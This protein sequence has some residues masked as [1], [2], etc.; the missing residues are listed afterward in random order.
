MECRQVQNKRNCNCSYEPCNRKGVCCDC[1]RYHLR[2]R[3]LPACFFPDDVE[4][5]YDRSFEKFTE[6]VQRGKV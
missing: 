3:Q 5:T 6:L 2:S 4:R 1:V